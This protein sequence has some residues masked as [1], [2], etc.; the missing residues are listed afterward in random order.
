MK[1]FV[2]Q[3][4]AVAIVDI[5]GRIVHGE[6]AALRNTIRELIAAGDRKI[7][8]N[9]S[10]VPYIDSSGIGELVSSFVAV[11]REGGTVKLLNLTRRVREVLQIVKLF[12][13]FEIFDDE[14]AALETFS[15]P[16]ER[17]RELRARAG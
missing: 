10:D 2:R 7:V 12:T 17:P 15:N 6:T 8:L 1:L 13:V 3:S 4:A 14:F 5:T 9:L 11:R 16:Q